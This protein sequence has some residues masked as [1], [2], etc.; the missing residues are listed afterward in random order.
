MLSA[1]WFVMEDWHYESKTILSVHATEQGASDALKR[2]RDLHPDRGYV[3]SN[4]DEEY[5]E[6]R[7]HSVY[8][9]REKVER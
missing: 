1:V 2:H 5:W 7:E 3:R 8:L 6:G 4:D 9:E